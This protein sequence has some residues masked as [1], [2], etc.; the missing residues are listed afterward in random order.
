MPIGQG[1]VREFGPKLR[2]T[3]MALGCDSQKDLAA[4][5][6]AANPNTAFDPARSY[7]WM[8]GR[9]L[10]RAARLYEE[11]A[12]LLD[13]GRSAA[14]LAAAPIEAFVQVVGARHGIAPEALR[15]RA[16]L[17][18]DPV[19]AGYGILPDDFVCGA[20]ATFSHAQS[21]HFAGRIIRGSACI[22][23][24]PRRADGLVATVA[25]RWAG[26]RAAAHGRAR[27]FGHSLSLQLDVPTGNVAPLFCSLFRPTPPASV[28]AGIMCATTAIHPGGQPPYA[29][30]V[31]MVRVPLTAPELEESNR[32]LDPGEHERLGTELGRLGLPVGLVPDLNGRLLACL[33]AESSWASGSDRFPLPDYACLVDTC[34]RL[35]FAGAGEPDPHVAQPANDA[36]REGSAEAESQPRCAK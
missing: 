8:Q 5:F 1:K 4:A 3:A 27:L 7:K 32:Y 14:W 2:A 16:G 25:Q 15:E 6:R 20:Y 11:W 34:N 22:A 33:R 26:Q 17:G 18:A 21:P 28:L 31:V 13:A 12:R 35:W 36:V 29:T 9:A 30:R 23:P 24:A 19:A 10:P